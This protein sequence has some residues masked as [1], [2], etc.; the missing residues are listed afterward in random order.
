MVE[1]IYNR[2]PISQSKISFSFEVCLIF[3]DVRWERDLIFIT[4][5]WTTGSLSGQTEDC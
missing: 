1:T 2:I 5:V 3:G 4:Q